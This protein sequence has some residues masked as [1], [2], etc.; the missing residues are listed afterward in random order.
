[1]N[2]V[3]VQKKIYTLPTFK[4]PLCSVQRYLAWLHLLSICKIFFC[5]TKCIQ[6]YFVDAIDRIIIMC[7]FLCYVFAYVLDNWM[8]EICECNGT[9]VI[10][11]IHIRDLRD[12]FVI[13]SI[14]QFLIY[15]LYCCFFMCYS[16]YIWISSVWKSVVLTQF[17]YGCTVYAHHNQ[18]RDANACVTKPI[19]SW[20]TLCSSLHKICII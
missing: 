14:M 7:T 9:Y 2:S 15:L 20:S 18:E 6:C 3:S 11:Y 10:F 17:T 8:N 5:T 19:N 4:T 12:I 13:L 16:F 1:M